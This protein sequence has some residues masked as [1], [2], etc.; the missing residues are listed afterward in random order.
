MRNALKRRAFCSQVL[1]SSLLGA[2]LSIPAAAQAASVVSTRERSLGLLFGGLIGDALGGPVEFSDVDHSDFL[3]DLRNWPKDRQIT[4]S[5]LQ[6]L[7]DNLPLLG[8]QDL[9]PDPA[10]YG[11]WKSSAPAGTLTDDSRHKIILMRAIR[12]AQ[13]DRRPLAA[14]HIAES[15]LSFQPPAAAGDSQQEVALLCE[16]GL[17]EY[18]FAAR[19]LLGERALDRARPLERLWAGVDNCSGQMMFP[20]LA[21]AYAGR[22]E[23]AYMRTFDLDFIDTSMARDFASALNAGLA[24]VLATELDDQSVG[25]RWQALFGSMRATDPYRLRDVPYAGRQLDRWLDKADEFV[26]RS[27][28]RPWRLFEL[29]ESEGQPTYWWD[30]HFTLLAPACMIK[31]CDFN[32]LAA[33]HLTLDFGHDTD[34]YAQVLGCMVGAVHGVDIWPPQMVAAVET[35]IKNDYN[36]SVEA[37][38]ETLKQVK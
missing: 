2:A 3:M 10:A 30:A 37:W 5:D 8:Y 24:A 34:S 13:A 19:W 28:G 38:Y 4:E 15:F 16:E 6:A 12:K 31:F 33:M 25:Q 26:A 7:A 21:V 22:P 23:Q 27:K 32:P 9:R 1:S 14:D 18:R 17:R 35:S 29:L 36:E 20:P 11:P